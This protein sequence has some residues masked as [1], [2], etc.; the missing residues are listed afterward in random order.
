MARD[1]LAAAVPDVENINC[2]AFHLKDRPV[3]MRSASVEQ[4]PCLERK[5]LILR[6]KRTA[7]GEGGKRGN[8][9]FQALK[10]PQAT[11][12]GLLRN[13]PVQNGVESRSASS[14]I[15]TRKAMLFA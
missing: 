8:G 1:G 3:N 12:A 7:F 15:S 5:S 9:F 2:V 14:V 4:V 10:P 11:L 6:R 13:Q